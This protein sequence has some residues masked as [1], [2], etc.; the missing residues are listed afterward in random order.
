[1]QIG[2]R[3]CFLIKIFFSDQSHQH[4][5]NDCVNKCRRSCKQLRY[6]I[7][8]VGSKES[9]IRGES[10]DDISRALYQTQVN[11]G[12]GSFEF[13]QLEQNYKWDSIENFFSDVGG[14]IGIW[15]GLSVLSLIQVSLLFIFLILYF[16]ELDI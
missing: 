13:F 8:L 15:L 14:A 4:S 16:R 2:V 3:A 7:N 10:S 9:T 6:K 1:M 5:E 11:L 12:W